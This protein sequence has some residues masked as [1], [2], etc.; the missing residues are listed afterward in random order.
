MADPEERIVVKFARG[1]KTS[2]TA[3]VSFLLMVLVLFIDSM[4]CYGLLLEYRFQEKANS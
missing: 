2:G 1:A 4:K 3:I